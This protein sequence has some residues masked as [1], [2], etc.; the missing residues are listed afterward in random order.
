[1][2]EFQLYGDGPQHVV[3]L[4]GWFTDHTIYRSILPALDPERFAIAMMDQRGYGQSHPSDGPFDI[5]TVAQD[6]A[7]LAD[8]LGWS[9]Y[10]V[11]GHS[12]GGK[13][14]LK[15]AIDRPQAIETV[16]A[17]TP[18]WA[19]P[20]PFDEETREVFR[21]AAG[22]AAARRGIIAHSTAG[23]CS[24]AWYDDYVAQSFAVSDRYAFGAYFESWSSDDFAEAA[25]RIDVPVEVVV[26][27]H[28][29]AISKEAVEPTWLAHLKH[30]RLHVLAGVGHYPMSQ[31]ATATGVLLRDLLSA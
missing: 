21:A 2:A 19:G 5:A 24:D 12:M 3:A 16:I 17:V 15:L 10:A 22:S 28:D 29:L 4:H 1:M 25:A 9:R 13:A 8:E 11:V 6:A 7:I 30:S 20:A 18:V 14:A 31:D 26:G 27:E 23:L